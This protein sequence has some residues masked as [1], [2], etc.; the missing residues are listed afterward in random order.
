ME[1][2]I[3]KQNGQQENKIDKVTLKVTDVIW[4][5]MQKI[6]MGRPLGQKSRQQMNKKIDGMQIKRCSKTKQR[7]R[8]EIGEIMWYQMDEFGLLNRHMQRLLG[9]VFVQQ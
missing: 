4:R 1:N 3:G 6:E 2:I 9:E 8:D 7:W 5:N